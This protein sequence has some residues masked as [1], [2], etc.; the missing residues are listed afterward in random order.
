MKVL[1]AGGGTGGHVFPGI[2]VAEE[3]ARSRPETEVVFIGGRHG[4][5]AQAVPESGFRI[6]FVAVRGFSRR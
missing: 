1:I 6:R 5:E 2:A 4:L 3:L